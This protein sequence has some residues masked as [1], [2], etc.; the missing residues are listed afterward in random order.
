[1]E[2]FKKFIPYIL[3]GATILI[4]IIV[5][6]FVLSHR[7]DLVNKAEQAYLNSS[8]QVNTPASSVSN[9]TS[10]YIQ[11]PDKC[12]S[13]GGVPASQADKD[14]TFKGAWKCTLPNK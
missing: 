14:G 5:G 8:S 11:S 10:F 1:M 7:K 6:Y 13:F 9:T 4:L 12:K 2:S 3:I